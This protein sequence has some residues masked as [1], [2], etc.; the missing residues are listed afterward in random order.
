MSTPE[1][2]TNTKNSNPWEQLRQDW[3][4]AKAAKDPQAP[5]CT[6]MTVTAAGA[7]TGRILGLR[8]IRVDTGEL[9]VYTN[10]TSPKWQ[11]LQA[12]NAKFEVLLFWTTPHMVQYRL[13]GATWTTVD[14]K[15]MRQQWATY[16][17]Q[18]SK[19]LDYYYHNI[20][21]QSSELTGGR[22][23]FVQDMQRLTREFQD[24][25][26]PFQTVNVGLLLQPCV[27]EE[28]RA[29]PA[30]RLHERYLHERKDQSNE[31]Q[32]KTLVP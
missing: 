9:L 2:H 14:E 26:V 22:S 3:E 5:F 17:P 12:A 16:K 31:W 24:E 11:H 15:S 4:A 18:R 8:D 19:L 23:S 6:L 13:S 30:D 25:E 32:R 1:D 20:Q 29:S 28:W 21:P 7:P 10:S 27:V